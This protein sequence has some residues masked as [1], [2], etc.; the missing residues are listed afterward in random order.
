M[1]R[2]GRVG[3]LTFLPA[4]LVLLIGSGI[5]MATS[6]TSWLGS[7]RQAVDNAMGTVVITGPLLSGLVAGTYSSLRRTALADLVA[8]SGRPV[9]GWYGPAIRLWVA[10]VVS[11]GLVVTVV[12]VRAS[13][14]DV[15][16]P[17][18]Q[19]VIVLPT[20]V[21][22]AVHALIGIVIGLHVGPRVSAVLAAF[23]SFGLFLL[24]TNHLAPPCFMTGGVTGSMFGEQ[25]R[26]SSVVALCSF[27]ALSA[28]ALAPWT[29]GTSRGFRSRWAVSLAAGTA[30]LALAQVAWP[31]LET[32]LEPTAISYRCAGSGPEVCVVSERAA[33][34]V[35]AVARRMRALASPLLAIGSPIPGRW[36]HGLYGQ[37][38]EAG[39]GVLILS[40]ESESGGTVTD[41]ELVRSL[42]EPAQC[43]QYPNG[44]EPGPVF[45]ARVQILNWLVARSGLDPRSQFPPWIFSSESDRWVRTTYAQLRRC[46]LDEIR[47]PAAR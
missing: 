46:D 19:L 29:L 41:A 2:R 10:A 9:R 45:G 4:L 18:R 38:A 7:W 11:L 13:F 25:Y 14:L 5:A 15:P 43:P 40:S 44:D 3:G 12:T 27:A 8:S 1:R 17:P 22:L 6:G 20:V 42:V 24:A 31:D 30:F 35:G 28:A 39:S 47:P 33:D 23:I 36:T 16:V 26:L 37:P 21:T 32:R 34:D